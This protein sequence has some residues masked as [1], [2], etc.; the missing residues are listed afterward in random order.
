MRL[1]IDD[2]FELETGEPGVEDILANL[3]AEAGT[4]PLKQLTLAS[5]I[6]HRR[7]QSLFVAAPPAICLPHALACTANACR[8]LIAYL[9]RSPIGALLGSLSEVT[10]TACRFGR[11]IH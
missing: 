11:Q 5:P 2:L 8:H 1:A 9:P 6:A 7:Y 3:G 4:Y 10:N